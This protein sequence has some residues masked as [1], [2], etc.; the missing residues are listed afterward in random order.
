MN[1]I[2]PTSS[3]I[4]A[5]R[6]WSL[7]AGSRQLT[8]GPRP[9]VMGIVNV[10]PDSFSDGGHFAT[11]DAAVEHALKLAGNGAAILDIGG[12]STRPGA[13][14]VPADLEIQRV[15]PVIRRLQ[16][17]RVPAWISVDTRK[18]AV[19]EAALQAG[20]DLVNDVSALGDPAMGTV[21]ARAG[22]PVVLMHMLG[23]PQTMQ[24]SPTYDNVV[25][26]VGHYLANALQRCQEFGI[27]LAQTV[28]DPGLGFGK[29]VE[30]NLLLLRDLDRLAILGRP[31]LLGPSRKSFL[32]RILGTGVEQRL[33]GTVACCV[34]TRARGAAIFRVHDVAEVMQA[35][36][37]CEAIEH[38]SEFCS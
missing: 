31:I 26:A 23:T 22:C 16:A 4:I 35:L 28:I 20:A 8:L 27:D 15:V 14:E 33:M 18:A 36:K 2:G 6:S 21:V 7:R 38:P 11:T 24:A 34:W 17:G 25:G 30:H 13:A 9:V 12:E 32:G 1:Q 3:E 37:V 19:A 10:T 5:D 29:T